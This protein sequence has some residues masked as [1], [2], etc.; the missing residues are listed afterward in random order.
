MADVPEGLFVRT[1]TRVRVT[2]AD[3]PPTGGLPEPYPHAQSNR[4]HRASARRILAS[5]MACRPLRQVH[6]RVP[7]ME[8]R[9]GAVMSPRDG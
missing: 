9:R 4:E 3:S 1:T 8:Q 2:S 7:T 6:Q 5:G